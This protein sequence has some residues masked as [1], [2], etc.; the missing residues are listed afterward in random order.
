MSE[1]TV[2]DKNEGFARGYSQ[3]ES[4]TP[5]AHPGRGGQN[6][7]IDEKPYSNH[8]RGG[9]ATATKYISDDEVQSDKSEIKGNFKGHPGSSAQEGKPVAHPGRGGQNVHIDEA[10]YT[11]HPRGSGKAHEEAPQNPNST[12]ESMLNR[13]DLNP[14]Q[15]A[16]VQ[17][18]INENNQ[19]QDA[20]ER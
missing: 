4:G 10:P 2:V 17:D 19:K 11:N 14:Q 5:V 20:V 15:L 12:P 1:K 8:P 6:V 16:V 13:L 18:R 7:H 3:P 9:G